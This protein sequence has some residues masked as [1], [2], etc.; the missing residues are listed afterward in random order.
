MSQNGR[1]R[2]VRYE[3]N[4][5]VLTKDVMHKVTMLVIWCWKHLPDASCREGVS[6]DGPA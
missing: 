3:Q 1:R 2:I 5:A 4:S 6:I